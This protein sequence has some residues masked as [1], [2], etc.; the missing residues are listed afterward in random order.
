MGQ[1]PCRVLVVDDDPE[2]RAEARSL[3]LQGSDQRYVFEEASTGA[4]GVEAALRGA[5]PDCILLDYNLPDMDAPDV[6]AALHVKSGR[7]ICPVVVLTGASGP[8]RGRLVLR[9]GAQDYIGKG[10]LTAPGLTRAVENAVERW[11][12]D[13][14]LRDREDKLGESDRRKDEFLA[15]LAHELRNPLAPLRSGLEV[16][17]LS[18]SGP[19]AERA[20][21]MM[22]RQLAHMVRLI[23]DL[24]DVSRISHGQIE[25]KLE[26]VTVATI[27]RDAVEASQA[28]VDGENHALVVEL[29]DAPIWVRGDL[30]RL[31]QVVSNLI[32][33]AAKY[34]PP[35]SHIRVTAC[36][37]AS[38]VVV[39]VV[40]DG[41]GI[42]ADDLAKVFDLFSQVHRTVE[43]AQGGLGIGLSLVKNLVMQHGGS[44][45]AESAGL[46]RGST[47]TVRIPCEMAEAPRAHAAEDEQLRAPTGGRRILVVDDNEDGAE[48]LATLLQLSGHETATAHSG[49]EALSSAGAFRPE[50]A[51]LDIGL[52]G[53]DGYELA[54]R[55]RSD[56]EHRHAVLV[57]LTGWGG[58]DDKRRSAEAGF[59]YHLTKPVDAAAVDA[60]L[61]GLP[62]RPA[63]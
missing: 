6:L 41:T 26:R 47:F 30:T 20:R 24:M 10:W 46:G 9:A 7:T 1:K 28:L 2:D 50:V 23:D 19:S 49:E 45:T 18:P 37:E 32:N 36:V 4:A 54:R 12:L 13:G 16:L 5:P 11:A 40:D 57:A 22:G 63:P 3:L 43:R 25:L 55:L 48:M 27:L 17:R 39:V 58:A 33:N 44:V 42:A 21:E 61:A 34:S 38:H 56:P 35:G 14:E 62:S 52:P 51:F 8:E 31:A 15:T 59:D 29:P 60:L 53:M